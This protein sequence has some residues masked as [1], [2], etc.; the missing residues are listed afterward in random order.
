MGNKK[1]F[2][3][4]V[5]EIT[6]RE[7]GFP[8]GLILKRDVTIQETMLILGT[9]LGFVLVTRDDFDSISDYRDQLFEYKEKVNLWL[10]GELGDDCITELSCDCSD[11][12]LGLMNMI[13]IFN[14]LKKKGIIE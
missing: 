12:Q 13:P 3:I 11:E 9:L 6:T 5:V 4:G 10:K 14:Y 8:K 2:N 1:R 7:N